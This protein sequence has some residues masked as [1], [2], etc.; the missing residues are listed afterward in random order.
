MVS[1]VV[2]FGSV[3][4]SLSDYYRLGSRDVFI[5]ML[6]VVA[7]FLLK[8]KGYDKIDNIAGTLAAACALCVIVFP[9]DAGGW[10]SVVHFV[11]ATG[12]FIIF[13]FFCLFLFTKTRDSRPNDLWH[14]IISFR[15]GRIKSNTPEMRNKK[16]RNKVYVGCGLFMLTGM[17]ITVVYNLCWQDTILSLARPVLILEWLMIWAFGIA[18]LVKG[19]TI[20]SDR[21]IIP[22][23]QTSP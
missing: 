15:F 22:A 2:L 4:D 21:N 6:L 14:T 8:Y 17:I 20:W 13:A 1:G 7:I 5:G 23:F 3:Q 11:S 19:Q 9:N 10:Q 18:W 12:L 16:K